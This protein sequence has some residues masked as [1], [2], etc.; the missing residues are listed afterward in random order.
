MTL[1]D[2]SELQP[3]VPI[4]M[5]GLFICQSHSDKVLEPPLMDKTASAFATMTFLRMS[6][7]V[8]MMMS[9]PNHGFRI[10]T[11]KMAIVSPSVEKVLFFAIS[12]TAFCREPIPSDSIIFNQCKRYFFDP[13]ESPSRFLE[14]IIDICGRYVKS[15]PS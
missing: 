12:C 11:G 9:E 1:F 13:V 6:I 4:L 3:F 7:P 14:P 10:K 8:G 2:I 15:S 5:I